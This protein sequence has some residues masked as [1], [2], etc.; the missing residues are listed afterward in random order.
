M[1]YSK[2]DVQNN[3]FAEWK[4]NGVYYIKCKD[5]YQNQPDES[6]CSL[7]VRAVDLV[8]KSS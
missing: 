2:A 6:K 1:E 8:S 5:D 4:E 7:I 3:H